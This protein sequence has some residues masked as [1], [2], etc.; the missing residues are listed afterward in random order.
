[1]PYIPILKVEVS[2]KHIQPYTYQLSPRLV[3]KLLP[4]ER[5][6]PWNELLPGQALSDSIMDALYVYQNAN[7]AET[8]PYPF[9]LKYDKITRAH[10]LEV[11]IILSLD[12]TYA[13]KHHD[14]SYAVDWWWRTPSAVGDG[15]L[16]IGIRI[17]GI[18]EMVR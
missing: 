1:M 12:L 9:V 7:T 11:M 14:F 18:Y 3:N 17:C 10:A 16:R 5:P 4:Y 13:R 6:N 8:Y 15:E 2:K